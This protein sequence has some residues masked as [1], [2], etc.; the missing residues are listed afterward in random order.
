MMFLFGVFLVVCGGCALLFPD[1]MWALAKWDNET[2]GV[3][4]ERTD[5]WERMNVVGGLMLIVAGFGVFIYLIASA[6]GGA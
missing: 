3:A 4:S 5:I 2:D 1:A 6:V